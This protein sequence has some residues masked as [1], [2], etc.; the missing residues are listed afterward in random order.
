MTP[1]EGMRAIPGFAVC[2]I[3]HPIQ[4]ACIEGIVGKSDQEGS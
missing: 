2:I 3:F 1:Q 4:E